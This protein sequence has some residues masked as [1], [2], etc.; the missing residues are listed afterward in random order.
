MIR[1]VVIGMIATAVSWSTITAGEVRLKNGLVLPGKPAKLITLTNVNNPNQ[2]P[3]VIFNLVMVQTGGAIP[4][5]RYFVP[6]RQ[7][8][9]DGLDMTAQL[10]RQDEFSLF[11]LKGSRSNVVRN[12]GTITQAAP[13]DKDGRRW[14][15]LQT[16]RGEVKITQ[17]IT[18]L[19]PTHAEVSSLNHSW[20]FGVALNQL[21][22]ST[23]L[24]ILHNPVVCKP[25]DAQDRMARARF[26][27]QAGWYTAADDELT[28]VANDFPSLNEQIT[29]VRQEL[30]QVFARDILRELNR[31]KSAGQFQLA[32]ESARKIPP[33]LGAGITR[34]V[35][36]FLGELQQSRDTVDKVRY[37]LSD[38]Q[39]KLPV[40]DAARQVAAMRSTLS[41]Q[42]SPH[43]LGSLLPFLQAE[44]DPQLTAEEKLALAY[45]GWILGADGADTDLSRARRLWD[46]RTWV[47]EYLHAEDP[48]VRL[49]VAGHL[50]DLEGIGPGTIKQLLQH[51][52]P[53]R[54]AEGIEPMTPH[55]VEVADGLAYW[56]VLPPEYSPQHSY[57]AVVALH[58]GANAIE[59]TAQWWCGT[60][61]HPGWASRR[62]FIT[63][64]PEYIAESAKEFT[65][66]PACHTAVIESLRDARMRFA[67]DPDRVFL[68]GHGLG[69]DAAFDIG[70]THPDEF[71]GVIPISGFS[72]EYTTRT[73]NNAEQ[74]AWYII[75]GELMSNND[76]VTVFLDQ[77]FK[78]GAHVDLIFCQFMGRGAERFSDELPRLFDWMEL[79][80]RASLPKEFEYECLR[81][82]DNRAHWVTLLDLPNN[83][84]LPAPAAAK[85]GVKP[86][87]LTAR[88]TEGNTIY[89]DSSANGVLLRLS[90][91][92]VDFNKRVS[93][94]LNKKRK[95]HDF[96]KAELSTM[97]DDYRRHGDRR[98]IA[99]TVLQF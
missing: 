79:H 67:I 34:E 45:S 83:F 98:R 3:I 17:G 96:V 20:D 58:P 70:M 87:K 62:G 88:V 66:S 46:A 84:I 36:R 6:Y 42:L 92:I 69:G 15:T 63:V 86:M 8:P 44:S 51:L 48:A 11:H 31:R 80:R 65:G 38:L 68:A 55:R 90:D 19:T 12:L 71:A 52:P 1:A 40:G 54:N 4:Y 73:R 29:A 26:C 47:T 82:A 99:Q 24:E 7:V 39:A 13:F 56:I 37:L 43:T 25:D 76:A 97:L 41:E 2:G 50:Q 81:Q 64:I 5:Q 57:P 28:S 9:D 60:D 30:R 77:L 32:E 95:F 21:S 72:N 27:M 14:V 10:A 23:V 94:H 89:V 33:N 93:V 85:G 91:D 78:N 35:Q 49:E 16:E 74:T 75:R 59:S 53:P 18:R 22:E 61:D